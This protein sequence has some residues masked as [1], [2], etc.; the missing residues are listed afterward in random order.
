MQAQA[1]KLGTEPV[2]ENGRAH[3]APRRGSRNRRRNPGST[4]RTTGCLMRARGQPGGSPGG[5]ATREGALPGAVMLQ[6]PGVLR[7][8]FASSGSQMRPCASSDP[9][10]DAIAL[11]PPPPGMDGEA[12][13]IERR[14]K[15]VGAM[16]RCP[17]CRGCIRLCRAGDGGQAVTTLHRLSYDADCLSVVFHACAVGRGR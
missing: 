1:G 16:S 15:D 4:V 6:F 12:T 11:G 2:G 10:T 13:S 17:Q 7:H 8:V 3:H 9:W 14:V 5:Q